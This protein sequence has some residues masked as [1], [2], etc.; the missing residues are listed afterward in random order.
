MFLRWLPDAFTCGP[1]LN[2]YLVART[3]RSRSELISSPTIFS[4]EP[5]VYMFAV[6]RKLPPAAPNVSNI[7]RDSSAEPPQPQSSPNVIVPKQSSDT[8]KPELP[9]SLYLIHPPDLK[10][11]PRV[12]RAKL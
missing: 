8:R 11:S 6:S 4:L 2:E 1:M 9:S 12:G 3:Q 5:L 10:C 7:F